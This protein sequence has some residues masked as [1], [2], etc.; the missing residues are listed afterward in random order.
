[1]K[2][3]YL[4]LAALTLST[5]AFAQTFHFGEG[6]SSL[7][8]DKSDKSAPAHSAPAK[9]RPK[10]KATHARAQG[11]HVSQPDKYSHN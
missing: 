7:S 4:A 1:M 10:H 11:S 6:Q 8:S 2:P 5:T 9:P 3:V